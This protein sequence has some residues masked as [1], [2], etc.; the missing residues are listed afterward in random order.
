VATP[1]T[2][3][4]AD[5]CTPVNARLSKRKIIV[6]PTGSPTSS[7]VK[8]RAH[9][10]C[11]MPNGDLQLNA[12]NGRDDTDSLD[13][14]GSSSPSE[15]SSTEKKQGT[16]LSYLIKFDNRKDY[17]EYLRG[18]MIKYK[19]EKG[20]NMELLREHQAYVKAKR[21]ARIRQGNTK[22][23]KN[24]RKR[25]REEKDTSAKKSCIMVQLI[26]FDW[27]NII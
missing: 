15:D 21:Q 10:H 4:P 1:E 26:S 19:E 5:P 3:K 18:D 7:P 27:I 17:E 20:N 12:A 13:V 24:K 23:Q 8:K 2:S 16:L 22:R 25:D 9:I 6:S 14:F 11:V